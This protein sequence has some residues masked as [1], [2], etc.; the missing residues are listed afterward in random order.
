MIRNIEEI[1]AKGRYDASFY[2]KRKQANIHM[3][4]PSPSLL[5]RLS[6]FSLFWY[7]PVWNIKIKKSHLVA[8]IILIFAKYQYKEKPLKV[9]ED[10]N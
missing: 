7:L 2:I 10:T 4:E 3:Y 5:W 6:G 1:L 8:F 9:R